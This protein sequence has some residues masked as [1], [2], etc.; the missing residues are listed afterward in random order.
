MALKNDLHLIEAFVQYAEKD[1]TT[2]KA[3][4][5]VLLRHTWYMNER[6]AAAAFFDPRISVD[7]LREMVAAL[8]GT[9][10]S[11]EPKYKMTLSEV[12]K[13]CPFRLA[14][15]IS[16]RSMEFFQLMGIDGTFL[17][18]DPSE[19][20]CDDRFLHG[21]RIVKAMKVVND[22]AERGVALIQEFNNVLTHDEDQQ[23]YLLQVVEQHR[24]SHPGPEKSNL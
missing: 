10:H 16:K 20:A 4:L 17:K 24:A 3:V 11:D 7:E 13:E 1:E 2:S 22:A 23:Q 12:H 18:A 14:N 19:W 15:F 5:N 9:E 21:K 6:L 8:E